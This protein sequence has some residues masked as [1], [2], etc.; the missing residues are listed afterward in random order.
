MIERPD[1]GPKCPYCGKPSQKA[2]GKDVYPHRGDLLGKR[3]WLCAPCDAYV[4]CHVGTWKPFGRLANAELRKAK[5]AAHAAFDPLWKEKL[6]G[7]NEAY[8]WLAGQ[9]DVTVRRC[10]I[11]LFN[12]DQCIAVVRVCQAFWR[13]HRG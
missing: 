9:L 2:T 11:G 8:R 13:L 7:R 6:M 1:R 12:L 3:F 10:H 5:V 4:G